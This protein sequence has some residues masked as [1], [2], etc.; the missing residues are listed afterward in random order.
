MTK[1]NVFVDSNIIKN[2]FELTQINNRIKHQLKT[3]I[4]N[5]ILLYR[6]LSDDNHV[7]DYTKTVHNKCNNSSNLLFL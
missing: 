1:T 2:Y 7:S 5:L 4:R 3:N 6:N